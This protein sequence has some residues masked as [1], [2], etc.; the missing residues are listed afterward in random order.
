MWAG[1]AA[2][3][4]CIPALRQVRYES[5]SDLPRIQISHREKAFVVIPPVMRIFA[6]SNGEQKVQVLFPV[7]QG[8][9]HKQRQLMQQYNKLVDWQGLKLL[10][11]ERRQRDSLKRFERSVKVRKDW[12]RL[13]K[14]LATLGQELPPG[15][16][17]SLSAKRK[18]QSPDPTKR[19]ASREEFGRRALAGGNIW[20][21]LSSLLTLLESFDQKNPEMGTDIVAGQMHQK[22]VQHY[23]VNI[24]KQQV[25]GGGCPTLRDTLI[26][27]IEAALNQTTFLK[28]AQALLGKAIG[29]HTTQQNAD[30]KSIIN[31]DRQVAPKLIFGAL[32]TWAIYT[33]RQLLL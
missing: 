13:K 10:S 8:L 2:M 20:E 18:E 22:T 9:S 30:V 31:K 25:T 6:T 14:E 26:Q 7:V 16:A 32:V 29:E 19:D 15:P 5:I 28:R 11:A 27:P 4:K 17:E 3:R 33:Q 21:S 23:W 1:E 24:V 12:M